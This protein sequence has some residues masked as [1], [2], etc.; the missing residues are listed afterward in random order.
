[1]DCYSGNLKVG[2]KVAML[3]ISMVDKSVVK[4]DALTV[5]MMAMSLAEKSDR[6]LDF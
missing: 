2:T 4:M 3:D 5:E 6:N 1:L